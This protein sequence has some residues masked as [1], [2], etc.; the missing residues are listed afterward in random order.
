MSLLTSD[1]EQLRSNLRCIHL[2]I[3]SGLSVADTAATIPPHPV[4][5]TS[6]IQDA[7]EITLTLTLTHRAHLSLL[8]EA[9]ELAHEDQHCFHH[10]LKVSLGV[11]GTGT[12]VVAAHPYRRNLANVALESVY[13]STCDESSNKWQV[14]F[15]HICQCF[16]C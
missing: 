15:H 3:L 12:Q 2:F 9:H 5:V 11:K 16:L 6:L 13:M 14:K 7:L 1:Q 4:K 8:R 10:F